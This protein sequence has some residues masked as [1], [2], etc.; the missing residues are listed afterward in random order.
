[1]LTR[2]EIFRVSRGIRSA[3]LAEESGY[4][5]SH[6]LRIRQAAI[7]PSRD[8][9][10]A[11][12][13]ALRRLSLED[14][15]A[16]TIFELSVEESGPWRR[17]K[18]QFA[19]ETATFRKEREHAQRILIEVSRSP[20]KD[21]LHVLRTTPQGIS[22]AVARMAIIE[23]TRLM[24]SRPEYSESLLDLGGSI[25]DEATD[26]TPE[27][28]A[29]LSGRAR[30]ERADALRQIGRYRDALPVLDD[31]ERRFEGVPSCTHELGR[32]WFRR[33]SIL[34][35]MNGLEAALRYVRLS[36][37]VFAA[38]DDH[39]RIAQARLVEGN[40]LFEQG[41]FAE[42]RTLWLAISPVFEA[43]RDR[44]SLASLWLNLGW[45][46]LERG[47]PDSARTWLARALDRFTHI[48]SAIDVARTRWPLAL[49]DAR[50]GN[51]SNG[52]RALKREREELDRLGVATEAGMV[53]LDIAEILLLDPANAADAAAVCRDLVQ[54]FER[55]GA[56]KEGLKALP[57]FGK[58]PTP[59]QPTPIWSGRSETKSIARNGTQSTCLM[60]KQ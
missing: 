3:D 44:H 11:I 55:A 9:I 18:T 56:S 8:A 20:R 31:A 19:R 14:V 6:V 22:A 1:V 15:R 47:D 50:F 16:E 13:S 30:V 26:L 43:S 32:A 28:R 12:V 53:A 2:L 46:D 48:H 23:G 45:C 59:E 57:I 42:A 35:K 60:S 49:T 58:Q 17:D 25:A 54:L 7:E 5:R 36:V 37:N 33:G 4:H 52:L 29:F 10:A 51:R 38:L 40:V 27:Y 34:F 24:D 41:Q 39:R 21:W